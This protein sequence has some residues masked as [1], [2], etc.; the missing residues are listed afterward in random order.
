MTQ[1]GFPRHEWITR[2][3]DEERRRDAVIATARDL[4]ARE[5]AFVVAHGR[6]LTDALATTVASDVEYFHHEFPEDTFRHLTIDAGADGGFVVRRSA[7]P[8]VQLTVTPQL[9][10]ARIRCQYQF[11]PGPDLPTREDHFLLV[12]TPAAGVD[13]RF[14]HQDSGH[15][16]ASVQVLSEYLL[17]PV[18]TGRPRVG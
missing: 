12:F 6:Q 10:A 18:F 9:P 13:A 16:F 1:E 8:S 15:V 7:F 3:A 14:K 11:T 5:T 4:A 2:L 17:T